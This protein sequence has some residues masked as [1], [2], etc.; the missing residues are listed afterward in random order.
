MPILTERGDFS[1]MH[2]IQTKMT[3]LTVCTIVVTVIVAAVV[4]VL[5]VK[6]IGTEN[7]E[8]LLVSLCETGEKN[9]DSYLE[10]V[11][12]S[13]E[14]VA[15]YVDGDLKTTDVAQVDSFQAHIDRTREI[16]SKAANK[17]NGVLTYYYRI[18]PSVSDTVK[19]FWYTNLDGNGFAEHEVTD[20]NLYN[21]GDTSA[22]V[23]FTV[24]KFT[25][26]PVW[27]PSYLTDNLENVRVIS[28]NIPVYQGEKFVGVVGIE[29]GYDTM[30]EQVDNIKLYK[31]GY[32]FVNNDDGEIVYHPR[33]N[34]LEAPEEK[35]KVPDGLLSKDRLVKYEY[36]GVQK[37]AAWMPLRNGMR[38]NVSVPVSEINAGWVKLIN[39]II[40]VTA[41]LLVIFVLV[42]IFFARH[43][44][45]P[46]RDLTK[47]A[48]EIDKDN[49][50]VKLD[51]SGND[52]IGVLTNTVNRLI[53]H[54]RG[55][56]GDL[57]SLAY[58]DALT[59][60]RNKGAFDIHTRE[61]QN[62][63][64]DPAEHPEF[65]IGIFDC[66]NL[67]AMNDKYGHEKGDVYL[68]NSSHLICRVFQHSP[69]FRIGGDEFAVILQ[70]TEY[71]N[72]D[73]LVRYF[74]EKSS[75]ICAFAKEPWEHI[76]VA[77]GVAAYDPEI[78]RNVNDVIRRADQ[79]MY[80]NKRN[81]KAK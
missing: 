15:S 73:A 78:D 60:M 67:K 68:K 74:T 25:G 13:V 10:S 44:T 33:F 75:E 12:Q 29:I 20:I 56:I 41:L 59:S 38:L 18:D 47:A 6:D 61:L 1:P 77:V 79:L 55:Y 16:F 42:S 48:E 72:R 50:D 22:L 69:V 80:E 5:A 31:N 19:G 23:W 9:L 52:E 64:N 39:W 54:L 71:D 24:P 27:L 57:N 70:N 76:R 62:R 58:G 30:A 63:M 43:F 35:L 45:K 49:Y 46:L 65:A 17:A 40:I 66:D 32:A 81:R 21:T 34:V 28:Y 2:S 11:E 36:D 26:N 8:Q 14:I 7:S 4:G 53:T 37:L 3:L 51:Y